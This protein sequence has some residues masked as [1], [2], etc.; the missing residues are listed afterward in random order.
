MRVRHLII[1]L[2]HR[3]DWE[4]VESIAAEA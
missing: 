2:D 4:L 3:G 1:M